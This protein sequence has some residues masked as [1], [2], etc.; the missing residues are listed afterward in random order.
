MDDYVDEVN[1]F[2]A[3]VERY[4]FDAQEVKNF[5][6]NEWTQCFNQRIEVC[7]NACFIGIVHIE[8]EGEFFRNH[9][10]GIFEKIRNC[11]PYGC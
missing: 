10:F 8:Q 5:R 3:E 11:K 1:Y 6:V 4:I 7:H 2:V 9:G